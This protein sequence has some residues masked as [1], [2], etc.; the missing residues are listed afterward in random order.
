MWISLRLT[1]IC[2]DNSHGNDSGFNGYCCGS[3]GYCRAAFLNIHEAF[4]AE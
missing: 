4:I 3:V 1:H 2:R